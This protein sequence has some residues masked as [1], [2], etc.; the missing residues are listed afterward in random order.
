VSFLD[1]GKDRIEWIAAPRRSVR[2]DP[3]CVQCGAKL[4]VDDLGRFDSAGKCFNCANW[5]SDED[6]HFDELED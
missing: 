2:R 1:T 3:G 5:V 4:E 6:E